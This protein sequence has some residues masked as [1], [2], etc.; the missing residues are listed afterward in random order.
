MTEVR[1][2]E[3]CDF[4]MIQEQKTK[5]SLP[6]D[7]LR[8]ITKLYFKDSSNQQKEKDL[9]R[10]IDDLNLKMVNYKQCDVNSLSLE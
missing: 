4:K 3:T 2:K 5:W 7:F 1:A 9:R 8:E 10:E 6:N